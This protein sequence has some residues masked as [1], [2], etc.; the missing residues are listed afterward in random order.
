[1]HENDYITPTKERPIFVA[2]NDWFGYI[3][4]GLWKEYAVETEEGCR[5]VG[6]T[7]ALHFMEGI[8]DLHQWIIDNPEVVKEYPKCSFKLYEINGELKN[9][10]VVKNH[11]YTISASRARKYLIK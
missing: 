4:V 8:N 1:M 10:E 9:G 7:F 5:S 6:R 2:V 11:V 3:E